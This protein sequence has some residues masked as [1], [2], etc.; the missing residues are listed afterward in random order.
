MCYWW[1]RRS[2]LLPRSAWLGASLVAL[3]L[4]GLQ[5]DVIGV[6]WLAYVVWALA[7]E[8]A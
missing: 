4:V 6:P 7:G 2:S 3:L 1:L 5:T 8:N